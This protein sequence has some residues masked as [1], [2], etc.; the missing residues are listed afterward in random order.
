M[1][2]RP[3]SCFTPRS[4][5]APDDVCARALL[6][7]SARLHGLAQRWRLELAFAGEPA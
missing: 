7:A 3:R 5:R 6:R 1:S 2:A 4:P